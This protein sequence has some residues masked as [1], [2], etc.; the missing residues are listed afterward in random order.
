[1]TIRMK[2]MTMLLAVMLVL[3]GTALAA[4]PGYKDTLVVAR[5]GTGDYRTLTEAFEHC[6]AYMEYTV[7]HVV[8]ECLEIGLAD[9]N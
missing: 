1:M 4:S 9:G 2:R 8:L 5:D 3:G 7:H 6:R